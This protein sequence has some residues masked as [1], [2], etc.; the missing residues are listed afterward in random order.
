MCRYSRL[1]M[2][3]YFGKFIYEGIGPIWIA[4]TDSGICKLSFG[5]FKNSFAKG[6]PKS[7]EWIE[8]LAQLEDEIQKI[9]FLS[10]RI[11]IDFLEGTSFQRKVWRKI[12]SIPF[13][14]TRN[15]AW[16]AGAI[17]SPKGYRAVANAC[18]ANPIPLIIPCHR[19]I[20]SDGS[21]GGF[22]G[23]IELKRK[24]LKLEGVTL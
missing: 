18:G 12:A 8:N 17:G 2:N 21:I 3:G 23:G 15:Y 11:K 1:T 6:L 22:S 7:I 24:L 16:L 10:S 4:K 14:Q 13:G 19:V 20:A 9:K 5:S